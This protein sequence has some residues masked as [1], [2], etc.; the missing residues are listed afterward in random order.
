MKFGSLDKINGIVFHSLSPYEQKLFPRI[1]R[2]VVNS[3]ITTIKYLKYPARGFI[4]SCLVVTWA[5]YEYQ[6]VNRKRMPP[7]FH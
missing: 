2:D 7:K 6:R 4:A 3:F 5:E 1:G